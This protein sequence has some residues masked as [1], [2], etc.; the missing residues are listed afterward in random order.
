MSHL[1]VGANVCVTA[2]KIAAFMT[3]PGVVLINTDSS[4][5]RGAQGNYFILTAKSSS[6]NSTAVSH[7]S[8]VPQSVFIIPRNSLRSLWLRF[9]LST[10]VFNRNDS[11]DVHLSS[12]LCGN[13]LTRVLLHRKRLQRLNPPVQSGSLRSDLVNLP[14]PPSLMSYFIDFSLSPMF[15]TLHRGRTSSAH[16]LVPVR[17][18][19][20]RASP[21]WILLPF[22]GRARTFL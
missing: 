2:V 6:H 18:R 10:H 15:E 21:R 19:T 11:V 4:S 7:R 14:A 3:R 1:T 9:C 13:A 5:F 22:L 20:Y 16:L 12:L 17:G 8:H